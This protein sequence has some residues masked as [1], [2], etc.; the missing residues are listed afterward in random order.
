MTR[1][2]DAAPLSI[3][4]Q[5]TFDPL[6]PADLKLPIHEKSAL[7]HLDQRLDPPIEADPFR[8][9]IHEGYK[10]GPLTYAYF[11]TRPFQLSDFSTLTPTTF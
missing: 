7:H 10:T 1:S 6:P 9:V 8:W 4:H 3:R 2:P 5:R 11:K